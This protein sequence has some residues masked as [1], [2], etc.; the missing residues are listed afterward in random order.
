MDSMEIVGVLAHELVHA[1]VRVKAG[2]GKPLKQCALKIG[3]TGPMRATIGGL[4]FLAWAKALL[5]RIGPYP[6]GFLTDT[7]KQTTRQLKCECTLC[8]YTARVSR[9]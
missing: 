6:A 1:T 3:L 8:G 7:P 5:E 2:H 4:E 9:K